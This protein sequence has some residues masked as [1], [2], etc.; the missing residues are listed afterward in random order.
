M[1]LEAR[2]IGVRRLLVEQVADIVEAR[3]GGRRSDAGL[4]ETAAAEAA[5]VARVKIDVVGRL[6]AQDC[7]R[8]PIVPNVLSACRL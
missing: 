3:R 6:V 7:L 4:I 2:F 8:L 5:A 1:S